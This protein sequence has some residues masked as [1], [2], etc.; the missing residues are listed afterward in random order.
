[1]GIENYYAI[2][3]ENYK[4][5]CTNDINPAVPYE[6]N[7]YGNTKPIPR[8][9]SKEL[10]VLPI[11]DIDFKY[12]MESPLKELNNSNFIPHEN[13]R[14]LLPIPSSLHCIPILRPGPLLH[15]WLPVARHL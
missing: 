3:D 11:N 14:H 13:N 15:K 8:N 1:M 12:D 4:A 10:F 6:N 5:H 2:A 9:N 7:P